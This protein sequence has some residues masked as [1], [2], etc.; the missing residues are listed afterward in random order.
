MLGD[1]TRLTGDAPGAIVN[2]RQGVADFERLANADPTNA[3]AQ[4]DLLI[5]QNT[6]AEGYLAALQF[7]DAKGYFEKTHA[8]LQRYQQ[9]GFMRNR[10]N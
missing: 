7:D 3:R 6:L 5:R 8:G 9:D 4:M 1:M 10:K 2:Y